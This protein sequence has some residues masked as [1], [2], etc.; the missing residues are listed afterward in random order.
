MIDERTERLINRRLDG[1]LTEAESLELD[2]QLTQSPEARSLLAEYEANDALAAKALDALLAEGDAPEDRT[3]TVA[4]PANRLRWAGTRR[5]TRNRWGLAAA[6]GLALIIGAGLGRWTAPR[7]KPIDVPD[8][9]ASRP[10]VVVDADSPENALGRMTVQAS[11]GVDQRIER[12]I[13]GVFDEETQSLYLLEASRA[14]A[15]DPMTV[16]Y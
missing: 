1:E 13:L 3:A 9:N 8:N 16:N 14:R 7:A 15:R 10:P 11:A 12:E 5:M 4:R 6:A 2:K